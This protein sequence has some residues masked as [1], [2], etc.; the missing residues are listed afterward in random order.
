[1]QSDGTELTSTI[2]SLAA[3]PK[4]AFDTESDPFHRY[5]ERVCLLQFSSPIEDVIVDPLAVGLP[6]SLRRLLE[7]RSRTLV[8]HGADYDVRSLRRA[9]DLRLGRI[10]DTSIAARLLGLPALGLKPLL[11]A[12]LGVTIDKAAQRSDWGRRPLS[13][14]QLEY[15]RQDTQSLLPLA[16]KLTEALE[17][18]GRL[19][20][21][22][23]ECELLR[24]V[25]PTQRVFDPEAAQKLKG[26]R[27][28]SPTGRRAVEAAYR[29]RED[30][31]QAADVPAF[32]I[33]RNE[34]I[35][36][37]AAAIA[38]DRLPD[39]KALRALRFIPRSIDH[40]A[41]HAAIESALAA[42]PA[43]LG[44]A[45]ATSSASGARP[46][47]AALD[48][49]SSRRIDR[50]RAARAEWAKALGI[51]PG[52]LISSSILERLA[53]QPPST[54]DQVRA[55]HGMTAWRAGALGPDILRV[56]ET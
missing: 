44:V 32:R 48:P 30:A 12:E 6:H 15:A 55:V 33:V 29:W 8:I 35:V 41:L 26:A 56:L 39:L 53:R 51:D 49:E 52:F 11:E 19:T 5:F 25:E 7:D 45:S 31:A 22:E 34:A 43:H 47:F 18:K 38:R 40:R 3:E 1:M 24:L 14:E 17:Q 54:I 28:L 27:G 16:A 20:W 13:R 23:E 2:D 10:F 21:L 9:F 46:P 37:L 36:Q 42:P 50:L 4:L